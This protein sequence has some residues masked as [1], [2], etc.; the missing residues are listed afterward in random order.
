MLQNGMLHWDIAYNLYQHGINRVVFLPMK[1]G[2]YSREMQNEFVIQYNYLMGKKYT[3][4]R[5]PYLQ[6]EMFELTGERRWFEAKRLA[7][8]ESII[9]MAIDL[10]RTTMREEKKYRDIPIAEF[11]PYINLFMLLKGEQEDISDYIRI[12]GKAPFPETSREAY[13][14]VLNKRRILYDFFEEQFDSGNIEYFIA[15]APVAEWNEKG[16]VNLCEG[17][18]RCVYLMSKGMKYVPV[19]IRQDIFDKTT[20]DGR[21]MR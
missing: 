9:W 2:F 3:L 16:Y 18:H 1:S 13:D 4:M 6:D 7:G 5:V 21:V 15:S 12:Y 17:Q 11:I 8:G 14:Y 10:V 20:S 19:R